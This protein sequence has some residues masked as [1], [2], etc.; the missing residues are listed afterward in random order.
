MNTFKKSET[1]SE[2]MLVAF[3]I[4]LSDLKN[5]EDLMLI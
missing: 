4:D 5:T 3:V 2:V 1:D